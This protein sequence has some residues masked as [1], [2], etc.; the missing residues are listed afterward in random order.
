VLLVL[1][2]LTKA[3]REPVGVALVAQEERV[4]IRAS[5]RFSRPLALSRRWD[6]GL[7]STKG[8]CIAASVCFSSPWNEMG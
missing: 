3:V 7:L 6:W 2:R 1:A 8:V 5:R 4:R